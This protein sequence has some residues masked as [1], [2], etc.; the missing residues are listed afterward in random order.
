MAA[1]IQTETY[2]QNGALS[3]KNPS[4]GEAD[5]RLSLF[6]RGVRN[7]NTPQLYVFLNDCAKENLQ[8]TFLL[9]FNLRD[10]RG[11]KGE[12]SLGRKAFVW[13]FI[14]YP[15]EFYK[16]VHLL[17]EYGRWDDLFVLWCRILDLKL[18]SPEHIAKNYASKKHSE[19][20]L[21]E[22][23]DLQINLIKMFGNQLI[24]DR[25]NMLQNQPISL[26]AK[27]APSE[28]G[29]LNKKY[30]ILSIICRVMK[31]SPQEYRKLYISPLR[32][33]LQIV[34]SL[35][36]ASKWD[37]IKFQSVPSNAMFKL[38]D[39]FNKHSP[40]NFNEWKL[41][42]ASGNTKINSKLLM[43]HEIIASLKKYEM[44]DVIIEQQWEV[45]EK[46]AINSKSFDKALFVIDVSNSMQ[47]WGWRQNNIP[48]NYFPIDIAVALGILGSHAS[49][50]P[51]HN[52]IITFHTSPELIVLPEES[53]WER[54]A[55]IKS[56]PWSGSTDIQKVFDLILTKAT[57][58]NISP[59]EMPEKIFIVSDMQFNHVENTKQTN[60]SAL[61]NKYKTYNYT[62]PHLVFWN[63][64]GD[65]SD[66]PSQNHQN[67]TLISG[68][69]PNI[70]RGVFQDSNISPYSI[71]RQI[72]D[73]P[74]YDAIRNA[75]QL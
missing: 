14:N 73:D 12:R 43:P 44:C 50:G 7:L 33:Y 41:K 16:V 27:W 20:V 62:I 28:K 65:G 18:S 42:L 51:W 1:L 37:N 39:A 40:D 69:C 54:Y 31:W 21:S 19:D 49:Q 52:H 30:D 29:S 59:S 13:L 4:H 9:V 66:F 48:K 71:M 38:R 74:R 17:P 47:T 67:T 25:E 6:F 15:K 8:D 46:N 32:N 23:R 55:I 11:G 72:I 53:L 10:C 60:L 45:L 63:V 61:Q 26:C 36:C 5:G 70:V 57:Q 58:E 24:Q 75:L 35:M 56:I 34:E 3:Y 22:I 68:F 2:T 64:V